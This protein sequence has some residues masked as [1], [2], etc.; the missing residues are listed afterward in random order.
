MTYIAL[1]QNYENLYPTVDG[2]RVKKNS[3]KMDR[4]TIFYQMDG[5]NLFWNSYNYVE[6]EAPFAVPTKSG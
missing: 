6:W 4:F 1:L 5:G 3:N 2:S